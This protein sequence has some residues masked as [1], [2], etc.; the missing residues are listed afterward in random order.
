MSAFVCSE[1]LEGEAAVAEFLIES[2]SQPKSDVQQPAPIAAG[3]TSSNSVPVSSAPPSESLVAT[4]PVKQPAAA[5]VP[6]VEERSTRGRKR[7]FE[8]GDA[9]NESSETSPTCKAARSSPGGEKAGDQDSGDELEM[10]N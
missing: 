9:G 6:A 8:A 10:L 2:S 4:S 7:A 3:A 1:K 5:M